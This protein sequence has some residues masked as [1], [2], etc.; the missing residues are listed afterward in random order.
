MKVVSFLILDLFSGTGAATAEFEARGHEVIKIDFNMKLGK[1]TVI[2]DVRWLPIKLDARP[3]FIWASPP[4]Q[5][6]S[7]YQLRG[8]N[9][10]YKGLPSLDLVAWAYGWIQHFKPKY[11]IIEN[12]GGAIKFISP[13]LGMKHHGFGSWKLWGQFP[14]NKIPK[15]PKLT[16][17]FDVDFRT[18]QGGITLER[19][20][21]HYPGGCLPDKQRNRVHPL[22][23][24]ALAD[25]LDL[26]DWPE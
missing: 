13:F 6:F 12:V 5:E 18:Y 9:K 26:E 19:P 8:L 25:A 20:G 22:L 3:D 15:L 7:T 1:P 17:G 21:H 10:Y 24:K 16:K 23:A 14:W 4:C 2:A 11:W